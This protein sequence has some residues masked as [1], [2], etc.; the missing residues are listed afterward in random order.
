[1]IKNN[2]VA[3][4]SIIL[5]CFLAI[6]ITLFMIAVI[7]GNFKNINFYQKE[8]SIIHEKSYVIDDLEK[9]KVSSTSSDIRIQESASD[10]I[11]VVVYGQ[12]ND[13]ATSMK[14][15][16]I[17]TISKKDRSYICF[18]FCFSNKEEII[19]YIPKHLDINLELITTSGDIEVVSFPNL[20]VN[21][22]STSGD[23]QIKSINTSVMETT[24]GDVK[25]NSTSIS[26]IKTTSGDISIENITDSIEL[27]TKSGDIKISD[28]NIKNNSNIKTTSGEVT[29]K[30]LSDS[31][32][33]THTTSGDVT[34]KEN[35]RYAENTLT[36]NTTSGDIRIK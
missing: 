26:N 5:L 19:I 29:I 15:N 2:K 1:M 6:G 36:I 23:I 33:E 8:A 18:G 31:Y 34:I 28:F 13:E 4:I 35:N 14:E 3:I 11:K 9:I 25:L 32:I 22:K 12:D 21:A 27:E 30:N 10:E 16:G 7:N 17:L 24:S 20:N